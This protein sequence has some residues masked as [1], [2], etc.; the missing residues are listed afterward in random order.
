[1]I[2]VGVQQKCRAFLRRLSTSNDQARLRAALDS[3][4]VVR[5]PSCDAGS[6]RRIRSTGFAPPR[7][8]VPKRRSANLDQT[9]PTPK[10]P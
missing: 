8:R 5:V 2:K 6:A 3:P 10:S 4:L 9:P 1:M 7:D